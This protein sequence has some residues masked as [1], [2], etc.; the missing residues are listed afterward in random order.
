MPKSK[1]VI[2]DYYY[3]HLE[4]EKK[5][6]ARL[7]AILEDYHCSTEEEVIAVAK[8][9][10]ALVVQFA[11]I[12]RHVINHLEKC[13]LIVRYA[14]GVDN[15]DVQAATEKNIWVCNVPD[16]SLDEVSNQAIVLL[17]AC[18]KKLPLLARDVRKG[19][20]D[21]TVAKP[22]YRVSGKTLGLVGLG[23]IPSLV[24][25]KMRGFGV[26]VIAHD[27]YVSPE[28]AAALDVRLVDFDT[29][30]RE[31]D[32]LSVHC[33]LNDATR[34]MFGRK[35]FAKMKNSAIFINTARGG[36]VCEKDLIAALQNGDI[37]AAGLDVCEQEP[38]A[39]DNPLLAMDNVI[40]TPHIAWYSVEAIQSLQQKVGEEVVRVLSGEKPRNPVNCINA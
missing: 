2:A 36:I 27:P 11:P 34:H 29:L 25:H 21:Y 10:D 26:D 30:L 22:L 35:Q 39:R 18:A 6:I 14:I 7:D 13:R 33:P 12:T 1:I 3:E 9:A 17:L 4:A 37:A 24:A 19:N 5:E 8:D 32:Y 20:W 31:S 23:R 15:I 38:I 40:V 28:T 16:Y